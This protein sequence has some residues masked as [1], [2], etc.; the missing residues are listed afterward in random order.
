MSNPTNVMDM[1][2]RIAGEVCDRL[3]KYPED[4]EGDE[5]RLDEYCKECPLNKLGI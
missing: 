4:C 5:D 2:Q 3:C 1:L